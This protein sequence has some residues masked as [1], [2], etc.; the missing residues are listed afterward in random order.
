MNAQVTTSSVAQ[1]S[2][3]YFKQGVFRQGSASRAPDA[4]KDIANEVGMKDAIQ[5]SI[6]KT[7]GKNTGVSK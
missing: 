7:F 3:P 6:E 4:V 2:V 5:E 1:T